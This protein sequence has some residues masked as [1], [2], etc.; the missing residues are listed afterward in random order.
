MPLSSCRLARLLLFQFALLIFALGLC[1]VFTSAQQSK[2]LAPHRPIAPRV[3]DSRVKQLPGTL[4]SMVGGYWR[5]N[6]SSR[7]S[8]YLRNDL[9]TSPLTVN[10]IVYLSNGVRYDL[11]S[12]TLEPNGTAV[13][14][15]NSALEQQGLA[16]YA[17]LSGY[18]E[19]QYT[20]P[21]DPLCVSVSS[22]DPIHSVIFTYSLQPSVASNL[23]IRKPRVLAG[24]NAVEGLWWK[25]VANVTGFVALS[26]TS[27]QPAD[28]KIQVSDSL[29][30]VIGEESA[31]L[32][33]HGTKTANLQELQLV[34]AGAA[35]GL[36]V[37][38]SGPPENMV[39]SGGLEDRS[40]G[41][42]PACLSILSPLPNQASRRRKLTQSWV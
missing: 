6:P 12:V 7:A 34:S 10:P 35:G 1:C 20:W 38:Y 26:N 40:A 18:V 25:P 19:V 41:I 4:R 5:I 22:F 2:V 15:I 42:L 27:A 32:S 30:K 33:P 28:A 17:D 31:H 13:I 8:I 16:S 37:L 39:I 21:W 14:S 24:M 23:P 9:E 36:R 29:G 11:A 3:T